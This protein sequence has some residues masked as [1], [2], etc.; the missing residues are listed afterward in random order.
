[1]ILSQPDIRTAVEAGE[2]AFEPPLD[3]D[4]WGEASVDLRLGFDF[5]RLNP[6]GNLKISVAQ[7]LGGLGNA[8]FWNQMTLKDFMSSIN[9]SFLYR[10][11]QVCPGHDSREHKNSGK[12]DCQSRRPKHLCASRPQ[13]A[14]NSSV[15]SAG[16]EWPHRFRNNEQWAARSRTHSEDRQ[17]LSINFFS[18]LL[19]APEKFDLWRSSD[20]CLPRSATSAEAQITL[21]TRRAAVQNHST[22][23]DFARFLGL[24]TSVPF[25]SAA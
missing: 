13:H 18:A 15:D 8:G 19:C 11:G 10:S 24:S 4:Q 1:M 25:C 5:T 3:E 23:T 6:T 20:R 2:I 17:A 9:V 12:F 22:V 16:V 14:S 21:N 7:G